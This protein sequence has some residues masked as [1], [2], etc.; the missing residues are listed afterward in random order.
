MAGRL[1]LVA[2]DLF[3]GAYPVGADVYIL[4]N[5]IHDWSDQEAVAILTAVRAAAAPASKL[6]LF[7]FV[8][9]EDAGQFEASDVDLYMLALVTGRERTLAEYTQ[10]LAAG[11]WDLRRTVPTPS[12]LILEAI[13]TRP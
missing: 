9:P 3:A 1:D 7:E 4:S 12:Q 13:P 5:I 10:L 8:I 2:G 6:L 11:G